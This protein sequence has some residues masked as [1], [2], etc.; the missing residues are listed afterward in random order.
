[1][2]WNFRNT[3]FQSMEILFYKTF[4]KKINRQ[5][6]FKRLPQKIL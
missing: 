6:F 1:M 4:M 2:D 5:R 3:K